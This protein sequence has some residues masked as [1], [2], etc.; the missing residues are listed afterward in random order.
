MGVKQV[1]I[2]GLSP[3]HDDAPFYDLDWDKWGLPWDDGYWVHYN[4]LFEMH[5]IDLLRKP[6]SYRKQ[7]YIEWLKDEVAPATPVYM[8]DKYFDGAVAYPVTQVAHTIGKDYFNSSIAYMIALAIHE[9][10][11]RIGIWGCDLTDDEE[12]A[13]Q[14]PNA[15]YLIGLARGK[16]IDVYIPEESY[17]TRFSSKGIK[18]GSME[19]HYPSRYGFLK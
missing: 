7:G 16:G 18:L 19:P 17:L 8:Q 1:A 13:Y 9:N 4:R 5:D 12:Y 10:Y 11:D 6:E 3:T 2:V 15:E 14:R